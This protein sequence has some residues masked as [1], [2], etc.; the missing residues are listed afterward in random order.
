MARQ[1]ASVERYCVLIKVSGITTYDYHR[2]ECV[3][4]VDGGGVRGRVRG[5][6]GA[7]PARGDQ[8]QPYSAA[9]AAMGPSP[10]AG[11]RAI[12]LRLYRVEPPVFCNFR[13]LRLT[14]QAP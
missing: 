2:A 13:R 6:L 7:S 5:G 1:L 3:G 12:D 11:T 14:A 8:R 9:E 4:D 10:R